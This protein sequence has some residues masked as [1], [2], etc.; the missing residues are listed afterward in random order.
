MDI[1]QPILQGFRDFSRLKISINL[2]AFYHE[3]RSLIGYA[4]LSLHTRLVAHQAGAYPGFSSMKRL[5]VFLLPPGWDA[6]SSQGYPQNQIRQY[7]FIDLG[8]ERNCESGPPES[9]ALTMRPPR[10]QTTLLTIYSVVDNEWRSSVRL[11]TK[12]WPLLCVFEVSVKRT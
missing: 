6:S 4:R 9:S 8:G 7:P 11:L 3:C 2:P 12:W 5:G 10:L 1:Q